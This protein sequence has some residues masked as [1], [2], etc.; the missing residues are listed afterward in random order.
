MP[1]VIITILLIGIYGWG[2]WKFSA[3]FSRTNYA[4]NRVALTLLWPVLFIANKTYRDNFQKAL[5]G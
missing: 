4:Q 3:G 2:A 1:Q 5:G